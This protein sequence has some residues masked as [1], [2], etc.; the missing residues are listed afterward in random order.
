M[1]QAYADGIAWGAAK[2]QCFELINAELAESRAAYE[3]LI[4]DPA[5]IEE[6]LLEG[7]KRA[8]EV[9]VPFIQQLRDAVGIRPLV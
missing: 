8:R 2:Q 9:A 5:K 6:R 1:K 4:A 3:E 7:A